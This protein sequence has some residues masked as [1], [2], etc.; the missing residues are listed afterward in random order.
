MV[1]W[2][3]WISKIKE[4]TK[5]TILKNYNNFSRLNKSKYGITVLSSGRIIE[6]DAFTLNSGYF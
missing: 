1:N 2:A 5:D 4:N 6:Q 3:D